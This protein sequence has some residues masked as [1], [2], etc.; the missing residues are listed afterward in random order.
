[1]YPRIRK[2]LAMR[3]TRIF[4]NGTSRAIRIPADLA[5]EPADIE[6]EIERIGDELR[7]R[8]VGRSLAGV[9][10]KFARFDPAFSV[11]GRGEQDQSERDPL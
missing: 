6:L 9:L 10:S 8:P 2:V 4:K 1:M 7:I 5:F 3:V 11:A